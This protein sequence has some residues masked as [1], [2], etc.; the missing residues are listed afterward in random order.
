LQGIYRCVDFCF[1]PPSCISAPFPGIIIPMKLIQLVLTSILILILPTIAQAS[2]GVYSY[3]TGRSAFLIV[4]ERP[5]INLVAGFQGLSLNRRI[6]II[7][8]RVKKLLAAG[9]FHPGDLAVVERRGL[10]GLAYEGEWLAIADPQTAGWQRISRR[11][12]AEQWKE[13]FQ[14]SWE[15]ELS[16]GSEF[17]V[18]TAQGFASWYGHEFRGRKT[19]NGEMFNEFRYTAAHR[20]LPFGTRIRV[21]N[22]GNNQ[23]VVVTV[24]DRGPWV[25]GRLLDLSWAAAR[26]IGI[27]GVSL[28]KMEVLRYRKVDGIDA[29]I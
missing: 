22:L 3:S 10:V 21:T 9:A 2:N 24:N 25:K 1:S 23:S 28:V 18:E 6:K 11:K 26:T 14:E 15:D 5:V 29:E 20:R 27:N 8:E 17:V 13:N 7:E 16:P 19:A 4:N 12:L